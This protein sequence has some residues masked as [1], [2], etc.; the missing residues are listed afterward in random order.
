MKFFFNIACALTALSEPLVSL[1]AEM[2]SS[3]S[4]DLEAEG[5]RMH[6]PDQC[7]AILVSKEA[8]ADG[9]GSMTTHTND[10]LDCDFRIVKV[11]PMTFPKGSTRK[12]WGGRAQYPRYVGD[13]RGVEYSTE[14]LVKGLYDWGETKFVGEIPQ[15]EKTYGYL[16]GDYGIQ[17]TEGLSMGEST[18]G[19]AWGFQSVPVFDG[20]NALLEMSELSRIAME[21]CATARCAVQT[22]GDLAVEYGF[23]GAVWKGEPFTVLGEAGEAMTV[24]DNE[25]SWMFHVIGDDTGTS[26]V[27]VAQRVPPG[28][29]SVV[30]NGFVI[31]DVDLSDSDNFLGSDNLYEVAERGGIWD[32]EGGQVFR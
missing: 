7:T 23:Y 21:R 11:P 5:A 31:T 27:W 9:V 26:A 18:C 10:C 1:A 12:I 24:N 3:P 15:V 6:D 8:A 20:G 25:E 4:Y 19:G 16:D 17:N 22:M 13:D 28:H 14:Y 29:V 2:S 30:A 32:K